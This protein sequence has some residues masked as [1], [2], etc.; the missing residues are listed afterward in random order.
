MEMAMT[1]TEMKVAIASFREWIGRFKKRG[2]QTQRAYGNAARRWLSSGL[3]PEAWLLEQDAATKPN[4]QVQNRSALKMW[5]QFSGGE[6]SGPLPSHDRIYARNKF[7]LEQAEVDLFLAGFDGYP[8]RER[9]MLHL[10]Y[11][12]AL[13]NEELRGLTLDGLQLDQRTVYL[14]GKGEKPR[15]VPF[16][17]AT[18]DLLRGWLAERP[19]YPHAAR[20]PLL[21]LSSDGDAVGEKWLVKLVREGLLRAAQRA[22]GDSRARLEAAVADARCVHLLRRCKATHLYRTGKMDMAQLQEFLG[23]ADIKTTM[24]YIAND[25][26]RGRLAY[27]ACHTA[28]ERQPLAVV[29]FKRKVG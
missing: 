3:T 15:H 7:V 11:H 29:E 14:V 2:A 13:R 18:E 16:T 10:L 22:E 21:F 27:D 24:L 28:P 4:T 19:G 8:V 17:P 1:D 12:S 20:V 5:M 9:A 6:F 25:P 26:E 23:H